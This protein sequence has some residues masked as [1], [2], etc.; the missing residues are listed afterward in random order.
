LQNAEYVVHII[1]ILMVRLLV[2][3]IFGLQIM[4]V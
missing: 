1:Q 2:Y 3:F 4:R